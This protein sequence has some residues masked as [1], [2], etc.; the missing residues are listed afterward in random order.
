MS[1]DII[2]RAL[3]MGVHDSDGDDARALVPYEP[4]QEV[5]SGVSEEVDRDVSFARDNMIELIAQSSEAIAELLMIAKQ[6]QHP[7][8][9]EVVANLLKTSSDLNNDLVG[10]HKKKQDLQPKDRAASTPRVP[11]SVQNNVFVG[12]TA[13]LQRMLADL[14][15]AN[16]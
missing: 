14:K 12:S 10:L 16:E 1:D 4:E 2:K 8:A 13:E 5:V 11:G 7:R 9:F 3:G 6:S 15:K